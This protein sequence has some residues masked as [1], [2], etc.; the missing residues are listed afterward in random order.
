MSLV[1]IADDTEHYLHPGTRETRRTPAS[2]QCRSVSYPCPADH[3][4]FHAHAQQITQSF[5]PMPSRSPRSVRALILRNAAWRPGGLT[6]GFRPGRGLRRCGRPYRRG[7]AAPADLIRVFPAQLPQTVALP[8]ITSAPPPGSWIAATPWRVVAIHDQRIRPA[9]A[10]LGPRG[11]GRRPPRA[12]AQAI[13]RHGAGT[14]GSA[15]ALATHRKLGLL[16]NAYRTTPTPD[17][18][19]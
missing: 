16:R 3:P 4:E 9:A 15:S 14:A 12:R 7:L 11:R 10:R 19:G 13:A 8:A 1:Q 2:L 6:V 17:R 5:M 18:C